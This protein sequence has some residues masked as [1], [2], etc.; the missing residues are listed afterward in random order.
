MC[1]GGRKRIGLGKPFAWLLKY[2]KNMSELCYSYEQFVN[3]I[4]FRCHL[5]FRLSST[6]SWSQRLLYSFSP[7]FPT[8]PALWGP[9]I[10][11]IPDRHSPSGKRFFSRKT[12]LRR[13]HG[14]A[15][16]RRWGHAPYLFVLPALFH[17]QLVAA[18][19]ILRSEERRVGKECE[20]R[21][22][23]RGAGA[24]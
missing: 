7:W 15:A 23:C 2:P 3:I 5:Y 4:L 21:G 9:L 14:A 6:A 19:V 17:R 18:V 1:L 16:L 22:W 20:P 12:L 13:F 10:G 24:A 8:G 11:L